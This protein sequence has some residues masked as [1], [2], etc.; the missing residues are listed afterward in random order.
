MASVWKNETISLYDGTPYEATAPVIVSASRHTDIPAFH[1]QDFAYS[2]KRGFAEI[3]GY[4]GVK[5]YV[6]FA[7]ARVFVFWSKYP[8]N[9]IK[10]LDE[11]DRRGIG[12]YFTYTMN[13]YETEKLEPGLPPLE[14]RIKT[15]VELSE[16]IGSGRMIW[17]FDPIILTGNTTPEI[18][19][20][21][22]KSIG[23]RVSPFT[24]KLV[25]SFFQQSAYRFVNE[26]LAEEGYYLKEQTSDDKKKIVR[27][28]GLLCRSW[29]I[30]A[31]TCADGTDYSE[32]GVG[33]NK[34]VDDELMARE[35]GNDKALMDFLGSSDYESDLFGGAA[36]N[37]R[38]DAS[39]RLHCGCIV[40]K[41]IGSY[42]T[43]RFGCK[44]CYARV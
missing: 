1:A 13:D 19:V 32:F 26:R 30:E 24:R 18:V 20:E 41:D 29:G 6:S 36:L 38:K 10:H 42:G 5:D 31:A 43:C 11:L 44:Y 28:I 27:E 37:Y 34:C 21:K 8:K 35:F 2:L 12:Y 7:N 16:R 33:K 9:I 23:D 40:S 14:E 25:F 17:R 39:Q 4:G 22:I 3:A 15:F